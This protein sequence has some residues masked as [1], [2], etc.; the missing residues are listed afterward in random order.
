VIGQETRFFLEVFVEGKRKFY[1]IFLN[2]LENFN[3]FNLFSLNRIENMVE[4]PKNGFVL[5]RQKSDV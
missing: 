3:K 1:I 2:H 4:L 5:N